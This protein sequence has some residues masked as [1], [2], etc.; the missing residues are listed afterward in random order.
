MN[1][2]QKAGDA[3]GVKCK[4]HKEKVNDIKAH[5]DEATRC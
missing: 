5:L 2:I 1:I 4:L 3:N